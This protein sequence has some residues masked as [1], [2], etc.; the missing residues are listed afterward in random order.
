[1]N[2]NNLELGV[3]ALVT[4]LLVWWNYNRQPAPPPPPQPAPKPLIPR[5]ILPI[6]K[7][8]VPRGA[9]V[10]A[11]VSGNTAPDGTEINLDF[12]GDRHNR[13]KGGSDGLG[14]CVFTSIGHSADWQEVPV[15]KDFRDWM[16][17]HPGGGYPSKV[18]KMIERICQERGV[19]KPA[20][21]QIEGTDLEIL[22]AACQS[23]RMPGVTYSF[24][25]T[26]RYGGQRIAHMVSLLH[27][28]DKWFAVCDNN[29][30][31]ADKI[32]WM[33]PDEFR[34]TYIGGRSGWS[35]ILL[36]AGPP[37]PPFN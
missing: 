25:P 24:S 12:P 22:K 31:G 5:P 34:R 33:T 4:G 9:S 3:A 16:T 35:V 8:W 11:K 36:D 6:P 30:P 2:R 27:A 26:G 32:E 37:P 14:L 19:S 17:R 1:M 10:E 15:L 21:V 18:D 29:Y 13:N 20:Y 23:G 7:P 28:D